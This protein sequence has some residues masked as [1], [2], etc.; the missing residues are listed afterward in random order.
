[1]IKSINHS[2]IVETVIS[3]SILVQEQL[4]TSKTSEK[5]CWNKT[6]IEKAA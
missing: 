3:A 4:V 2:V 5:N 1:M 6:T